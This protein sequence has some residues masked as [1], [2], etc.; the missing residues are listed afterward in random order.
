MPS[1]LANL[2]AKAETADTTKVKLHLRRD[3]A[4]ELMDH[5]L[6]IT[7]ISVRIFDCLDEDAVSEQDLIMMVLLPEHLNKV[8]EEMK[9]HAKSRIAEKTRY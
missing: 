4:I 5:L 7:K 6:A 8:T 1:R 9:N 3:R 2:Q